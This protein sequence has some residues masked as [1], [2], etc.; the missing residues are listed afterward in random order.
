MTLEEVFQACVAFGAVAGPVVALIAIYQN[1]I[2]MKIGHATGAVV[3]QTRDSVNG[4]LDDR[5][6]ANRIEGAAEARRDD[7]IA[8]ENSDQRRRSTDVNKEII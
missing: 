8:I 4:I 6:K 7:K 2:I 5:D 3:R 1:K